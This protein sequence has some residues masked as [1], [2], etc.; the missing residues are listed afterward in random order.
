MDS[1]IVAAEDF[2]REVLQ[3]LRAWKASPP[4]LKKVPEGEEVP[5]ASPEA[6]SEMLDVPEAAIAGREPDIVR[7]VQESQVTVSAS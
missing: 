2:Y 6:L 7:P 1:V 3:N 5:V 4:K